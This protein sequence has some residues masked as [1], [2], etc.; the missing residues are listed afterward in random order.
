MSLE[1]LFES[2]DEKVFTADLK[3]ALKVEFNEAVD[4]KA[5]VI[6]DEKIEEEIDRLEEKSE[7][8]ISFLEEKAEEYT[9]LKEQEML[10][11]LDKY[12]SRVVE[13]FLGEAEESLKESAKAEKADMIIEAFDSMLIAAGVEVSRIAEAKESSDVESKLEESTKRYDTLVSENIDLQTENER[14]IKM[15]VIAEMTEGLSIVEREKFQRLANLVEFTKDETFADKLE[16]IKESVKGTVEK[17]KEETKITES[18]D[19]ERP[20]WAHLI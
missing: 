7:Q 15:G 2:L 3:E 13:E 14:L 20:A 1:K 6:A 5:A 18:H 11:A 12:L 4:A 8:H 19:Q 16:T 9:Q 10:D 17:D